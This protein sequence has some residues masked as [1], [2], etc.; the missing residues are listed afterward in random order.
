MTQLPG[1]LVR[2]E[3]KRFWRISPF[4][5]GV[6]T[7]VIL[8]RITGPLFN[9]LCTYVRRHL[10]PERSAWHLDRSERQ[11]QTSLK[12]KAY[13]LLAERLGSSGKYNYWLRQQ[14][15]ISAPTLEQISA[16]LDEVSNLERGS[17]VRPIVIIPMVLQFTKIMIV[18]AHWFTVKALPWIYWWS[19]FSVEFLLLMV[20][21]DKL[22]ERDMVE[23]ERILLLSVAPTEVVWPNERNSRRQP[24]MLIQ[25]TTVS[26]PLA[27][28][29]DGRSAA[30][31]GSTAS[32]AQT[33]GPASTRTSTSSPPDLEYQ[34]DPTEVAAQTEALLA[35][36]V[37]VRNV[38]RNVIKFRRGRAK[39]STMEGNG[40][41]IFYQ[42]LF[43]V[44][45]QFF[46]ALL[47]VWWII[48]ALEDLLPGWLSTI[49]LI[50]SCMI[51]PVF[52]LDMLMGYLIASI[53]HLCL[54]R[55]LQGSWSAL[56]NWVTF[57]TMVCILH[58]YALLYNDAGTKKP[59]WL[60]WLG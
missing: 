39:L 11:G 42:L 41:N 25:S 57:R 29:G 26:S 40:S 53:S 27:N 55:P 19:W 16:L 56:R 37:G 6:E 51:V 10:I 2:G 18:E 24:Q 59:D 31:A 12:T 58:Y 35:R 9:T 50:G 14:R 22:S 33:T 4:L 8:L 17:T 15:K 49:L 44:Y 20:H 23:A 36:V 5:S 47:A 32:A 3:S 48:N 43:G 54:R 52:F 34:A 38:P 28:V 1:S 21:G 13:A 45:G 30:P 7:M 46:E 60:D